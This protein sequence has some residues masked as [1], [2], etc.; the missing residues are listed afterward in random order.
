MKVQKIVAITLALSLVV[1]SLDVGTIFAQEAKKLTIAVVDF[2]NTNKDPELDYLVKG[3]PE[4]IITYLGKRGKVRIVE[5]ARLDAALKE[6]KLGISGIV[7][8][9]TAV[10]IGKAVGAT[11]IIVGSFIRVAGNI[12]I[13]AR[14]IDVQTGEIITAEQVQGPLNEVFTLMDQT[15]E[16]MW[17][18]LVGRPIEVQQIPITPKKEVKVGKPLYKRWWFWGILGAV[19]GGIV[20]TMSS[21]QKEK[22]EEKKGTLAITVILSFW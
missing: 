8:E 17:A 16:A 19:G 10:K 12:R 18:K 2:T 6:L 21:Q 22:E 15:S 7:D 20:Y 13:N 4:S 3:I 14:L 1:S 11:A 5:R 9:Q